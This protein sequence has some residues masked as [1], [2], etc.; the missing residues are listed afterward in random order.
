MAVLIFDTGGLIALER[1]NRVATV[2][3][4]AAIADE[5]EVLTSSACIAEVWRDPP[6]QARLARAMRGFLE[7]PLDAQQAR[8]AGILLARSGAEDI[9]DAAVALLASDE[10]T[11]LTSDPRDMEHLLVVA[12]TNARVRAL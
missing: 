1:G 4:D 9:A 12:G 8:S 7:R 3:L 5:I 11:I 10:D 6:R 2:M